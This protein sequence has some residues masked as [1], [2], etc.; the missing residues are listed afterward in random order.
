MQEVLDFKVNEDKWDIMVDDLQGVV[1]LRKWDE[2]LGRWRWKGVPIELS[3]L[4]NKRETYEGFIALFL[5]NVNARLVK[6]Y[7]N[8]GDTELKGVFE[9]LVWLLS[10]HLSFNGSAVEVKGDLPEWAKQKEDGQNVKV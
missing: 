7:G 2:A 8:I 5:K 10:N 9:K 4:E 3:M 6:E 1:T